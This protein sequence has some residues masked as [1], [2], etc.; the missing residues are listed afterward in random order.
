MTYN[1]V[2]KIHFEKFGVDPVEIGLYWRFVERLIIK[3]EDAIDD[4]K[5]YNEY[6]ELTRRQKEDFLDAS[7]MF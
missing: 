2:K 4:N 3:I 6:E 7:L 1:E 5:P